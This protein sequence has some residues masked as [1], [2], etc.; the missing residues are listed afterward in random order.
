MNIVYDLLTE[1]GYEAQNSFCAVWGDNNEI[2]V[3]PFVSKEY[4]SQVYLVVSCKNGQLDSIVNTDY[5]K[6]IAQ[7]FRLQSFHSGDMDKNT[8]L[9][10]LS[11]H[12]TDESINVSA[13][14]KI[15]DDPYYFKK[16]C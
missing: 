4:S 10:I 2:E 6:A 7:Q 12:M 3:T 8:S 16:Y 14:V 5:V 1:L 9:L 13:K 15:E 11:M